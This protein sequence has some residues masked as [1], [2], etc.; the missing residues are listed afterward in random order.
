ML[1]L[2][3]TI[4]TTITLALFGLSFFALSLSAQATPTINYQ[5]K[6]TDTDGLAVTD[7]TYNM[8]F[9]LYDAVGVATTSAVWTESLTGVNQVQVTNGL[10][11]IML[12]STT[13]LTS[14]D[15][16]QPLYLGVEI[17][18][19]GAPSWDG[20]MSPRKTL[21]TVPAAFEARQLGGVA[22]SSFLRSDQAD[23]ATSLL[24]FNG[25]LLSSASSTISDLTTRTATTTNFIIN[26]ELFTS[27]TGS[28]LLNSGGVLSVSSSSLNISLE[29]LTDVSSMTKNFGD[30]LYWNGSA[31]ADLATSSLNVALSDTTGNLDF[32][33][34]TGTLGVTRGGTGL[35]S[36]ATGD[37][38]YGSGAN[39]VAALTAGSNGQILQLA[40]GV[41]TWSATSSLGFKESPWTTSGSDIS[42]DGGNVGIGTDLPSVRLSVL[43]PNVSS[44]RETIAQFGIEGV[45]NSLFSIGNFTGTN[46]KFIPAF[47]GYN[48]N[49]DRGISLAFRG[50]LEDAYDNT[51]SDLGVVDFAAVSTDVPTNP[52]NNIGVVSN[53]N[54]FSFRNNTTQVM[55]IDV[56][57]NVGIG[58]TNPGS[59]LTVAGNLYLTGSFRDSTN[60]SGVAGMILQTTGTGTEW[61]ATST[62]GITGGGGVAI[63]EDLTDVAAMTKTYG[64]LLTWNGSSW[65]NFATSSL[66]VALSD[67]TGTLGV[68]RGGTGL[69][70][71]ATGDII[72]GSGANTVAALGAGSNGQILQLAGGVPTWSATSSLGFKESP[73]T[74]SGSDI[75]YDGGNV[76]I[77]TTSPTSRLNIQ[78]TGFSGAGVVGIDQYFQ[79][80]NS[81]DAAVQYGNRLAFNASN[82]ATTT[83]IGS[84]ININDDTS[85]A[86]TV[87]GLEVQAD[88]GPNT[89]GENTAI[90][91]FAR[92]FG[93]R[94]V[95]SGDAGGSFEPAGGFFATEGTTQGNA[96]RGYSNS[97][98]TAS[99]LA[100]FQDTS[101][102]TGTGLQMNFGNTTGDFSSSTSKYLDFQNAGASVFTVSAFGTTTIGDGTTNNM[103][104]LQIGYG[105]ICVDNDGSC[106]ASTTGR[107]TAVETLTGNSDL[108]EMYF[109]STDLEAGEIVVM[110]SGLSI[111]R[112]TTESTTP[113]IGV[114]STKPGLTLGFDDESL[115]AGETGYPVALSGRVPVKLSTENGPI[116]AGDQLML[117]T[118][119]GVAMKARGVGTVIGT[120]L[121]DFDSNR[122]YSETFINQFGDDMVDPVYAP[123]FTNTDPRI[124]DGCYYSGGNKVGAGPCVPLQSTSSE[125]QI[126]EANNII[127]NDSVEEA[128]DELREE[129]SDTDYLADGTSVQVGQIIMFVQLKER[130]VDESQ[131]ASLGVLFSTSSIETVGDEEGE[132]IFDR[133]VALANSF[134]DGVFSIFELRADRVE[135]ANELCLDGVCINADDL[136]TILD[137]QAAAVSSNGSPVPEQEEEESDEEEEFEEPPAPTTPTSIPT[138]TDDT[139]SS[140]DEDMASSTEET[141]DD[142]VASSTLE[143]NEETDE[144]NEEDVVEYEEGDTGPPAEPQTDDYPPDQA[145]E[146]LSETTE[147]KPAVSTT[148]D[149]SFEQ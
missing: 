13:P 126:E 28:G 58:T 52:N 99:L 63:L 67:T 27:L 10:F 23:I 142:T 119:P 79:T 37:I 136:R 1:N 5:G 127:E 30:L 70:S 60:A 66:N 40:G 26:N 120:A 24:T 104:G 109:S 123:V 51:S 33:R 124:D 100:L 108:A 106:T 38:I 77:G 44:S 19:A 31:W 17:G 98:T 54:L 82:T 53:K 57:G 97:I 137:G 139:A 12:G 140:T 48:A 7:G 90:S 113:I 49:D 93:V 72:Y 114:I 145:E 80:E 84:A 14:V 130:W 138:T 21:G 45:A 69:T 112:A 147:D 86:N 121:E 39:T 34:T 91:G 107:I 101:T 3:S 46:D 110:T 95:T 47:V 117:S 43:T 35:T 15:F 64:D 75:S 83:I 133:L 11:S 8:R 88:R 42:Y 85:F 125:A 4:W 131:L 96:V 132:T 65:S 111:D 102:F 148:T 78:N 73:W 116:K 149:D 55:T 87:R 146:D 50:I 141:T 16:N 71:V 118:L 32:T 61:V 68:T 18:G 59:K 29:G 9:F 143:S 135:I 128:L 62:L 56:D 6:L 41:P 20:E 103:A 144:T 89:Q 22:S 74:T 94:G 105:G 92:T 25:G 122:Q 134:I 129:G 115:V 81:V 36:V 76:G 2:R